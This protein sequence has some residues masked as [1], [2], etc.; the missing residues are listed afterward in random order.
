[1]GFSV[2]VSHSM[3]QDDL[4]IVYEAAK[5]AQLRGIGCYIAE[6]DWQFGNSLP[7]KIENAIRTSDCLVA[8]WTQGGA[9]SAFVNQEI[10]FARACGKTRILVVER[11]VP[12]KGFEIDKEYIEL[13][14]RNPL[15]A[16]SVLNDYLSRLKLGKEQT[17]LAAAIVLGVIGRL[18]LISD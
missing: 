3:R 5:Q 8:F 7:Q 14:R 2:F 13:D 1:M 9:Y 10:G 12:V 18:V 16:I 6:R 11:G 17:Q 4:A 15:Q